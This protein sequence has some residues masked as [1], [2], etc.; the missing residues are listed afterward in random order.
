VRRQPAGPSAKRAQFLQEGDAVFHIA[1]VRRVHKGKVLYLAQSYGRH[2]QDHRSQV[3]AQDFRL[4]ERAAGVEVFFRVEPHADARPEAATTTGPLVG[5]SLR[6]G[7]DGQALHLGAP[8]VA[9]NASGTRVDH[10]THAGH[11]Q[12]RFRHV[13]G[14]DRS[15]PAVSFEYPVLLGRR[16]TAVQGQDFQPV[17]IRLGKGVRRVPHLAL[18]GQEDEDVTRPL[19]AK[20]V[21]RVTDRLHLVSRARVS[22]ARVS[23]ARVSRACVNRACVVIVVAVLEQRTVPDLDGIGPP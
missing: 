23:R 8:A 9:G 20:L 13:R 17:P 16:K 7:L 2:L 14:Q 18:A 22:R 11:G 12:R 6:D 10:V 1:L 15:T 5:R 4:G 19:S 21:H 3:R